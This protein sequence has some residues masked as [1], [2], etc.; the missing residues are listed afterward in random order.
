[1]IANIQELN[2]LDCQVLMENKNKSGY[3]ETT[4]HGNPHIETNSDHKIYNRSSTR[5]LEKVKNGK[6]LLES[7]D[8]WGRIVRADMPEKLVGRTRESR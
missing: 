1:M 4:T 7:Q 2:R 5:I 8:R 3:V 6:A